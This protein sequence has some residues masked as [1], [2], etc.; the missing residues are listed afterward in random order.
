MSMTRQ[1]LAASAFAALAAWCGVQQVQLNDLRA[2]DPASP[3]DVERAK[4]SLRVEL[5]FTQTALE[6]LQA[7]FA[8]VEEAA[9]NGAVIA[10]AFR[11]YE[12]GSVVIEADDATRYDC[13][14]YADPQFLLRFDN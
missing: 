7:D 14:R 4:E 6:T 11:Q 2:A 5:G 9:Q 1:I 8:R 13:L 12:D 10:C 3:A